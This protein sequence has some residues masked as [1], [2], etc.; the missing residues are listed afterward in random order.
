MFHGLADLARTSGLIPHPLAH[1]FKTRRKR[2]HLFHDT[3]QLA[4]DILHFVSRGLNNPAER[5]HFRSPGGYGFFHLTHHIF[6]IQCRHRSLVRQS[7]D[8]IG[9]HRKPKPIFPRFLRFDGGI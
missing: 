8:L 5:F 9:N 2:P 4:A 6:D 7:P 3:A 1:D